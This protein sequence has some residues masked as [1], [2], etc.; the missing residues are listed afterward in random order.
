MAVD[1][2]LTT[3]IRVHDYLN[4]KLQT[5][6]DLNSI[7]SLLETVQQQQE[8]LRKQVQEHPLSARHPLT[9]TVARRSQ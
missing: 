3:D 4:D 2:F 6:S 8:L 9:C 5:E 7:D 1:A